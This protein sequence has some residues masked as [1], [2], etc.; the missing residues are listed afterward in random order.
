MYEI[1]GYRKAT[2][3]KDGKNKNRQYYTLFVTYED[4]N[5]EGVAARSVFVWDDLIECSIMIGKKVKI[6]MNLEGFIQSVCD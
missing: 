4:K 1:V 5:V 3:T 6:N 2:Y